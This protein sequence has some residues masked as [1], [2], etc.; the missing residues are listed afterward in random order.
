MQFLPSHTLKPYVKGYW[1]FAT[2]KDMTNQTFFPSGYIDF[3]VN[4]SNGSASTIINGR[5]IDMPKVE[6]LGQLTKPTR[7]TVVRGTEV[8]IARIH[9]FANALFFPNPVSGFT[10]DSVDL[11]GLLG[12]E[13]IEFY[14]K[15]INA[16]TIE[17]KVREL[18]LFL[19]QRLHK[20]RKL[21][22]KITMLERI[23]SHI[24][25]EG[26]LFNMK[27][28]AGKYGFPNVTFRN[29][30]SIMWALH[31]GHS[32]IFNDLIKVCN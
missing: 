31:R 2:E 26:E 13:S 23:C 6:V 7:L 28:L 30:F 1:V 19:V 15:L 22:N 20:S 3:A 9:P 4:I 12:K 5:P 32:F 8:L 18:D 16:G 24:G 10:N 11:D 14:D 21:D 27:F 25:A 29:C 17:Q